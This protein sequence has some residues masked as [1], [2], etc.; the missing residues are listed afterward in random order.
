[1]TTKPMNSAY[2]IFSYAMSLTE[3]EPRHLNGETTYK[4]RFEMYADCNE[5]S[6]EWLNSRDDFAKRIDHNGKVIAY[7]L[8]AISVEVVFEINN[9]MI[10][11]G[12]NIVVR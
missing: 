5:T 7:Y 11:D 6:L 2:R 12:G 8:G 1:M 10:D 3:K 9:A 4:I